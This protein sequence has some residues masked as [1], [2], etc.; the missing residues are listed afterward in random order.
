MCVSFIGTSLTHGTTQCPAYPLKLSQCTKFFNQQVP[1]AQHCRSLQQSGYLCALFTLILSFFKNKTSLFWIFS[2]RHKSQK[3]NELLFPSCCFIVTNIW[4][5]CFIH[6]PL[7]P[8]HYFKA[9]LRYHKHCLR[10]DVSC[11]SLLFT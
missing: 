7:F 2:E 6:S 3:N 4:S 9:Y 10:V 1:C 11:S 5:A 8:L